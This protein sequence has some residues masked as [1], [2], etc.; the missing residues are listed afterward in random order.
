MKILNL[1]K[2][3]DGFVQLSGGGR[4]IFLRAKR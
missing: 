2:K 4:E 1:R 3:K